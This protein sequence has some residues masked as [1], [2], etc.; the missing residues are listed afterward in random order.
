MWLTKEVKRW[1]FIARWLGLS[2]SEILRIENDNPKDSLEQC[3]QMFMLWK[4][5]YPENFTY[6]VLG[7]ALREESQELFHDYVKVVNDIE[8]NIDF[9]ALI[10]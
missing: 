9:P 7:G 3:Y 6:P 10:K 5:R 4:S 8:N 1:K 2:E